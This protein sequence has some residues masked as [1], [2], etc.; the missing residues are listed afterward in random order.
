MGLEDVFCLCISE[1]SFDAG[2]PATFASDPM[3]YFLAKYRPANSF[4]GTSDC[5]L[6]LVILQ[7][8]FVQQFIFVISPVIC[9]IKSIVF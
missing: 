3:S 7:N 2:E 8:G 9:L 1:L 4:P 5:C 6:A